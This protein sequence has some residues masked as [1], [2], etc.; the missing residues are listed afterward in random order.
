MLLM[1]CVSVNFLVVIFYCGP[2][3]CYHWENWVK[4]VEELYE[5]F[6]IIACEY[7]MTLK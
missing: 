2:T 3:R 7:T 1:D 5:L 4:D 6:L